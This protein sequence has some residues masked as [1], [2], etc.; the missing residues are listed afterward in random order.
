[1]VFS[2]YKFLVKQLILKLIEAVQRGYHGKEFS[3]EQ[4]ANCKNGFISK[5]H[6]IKAYRQL[7]DVSEKGKT[8]GRMTI[9]QRVGMFAVS[10]WRTG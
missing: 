8:F 4:E 3:E 10:M 7:T 9:Y 1:M 2:S 6:Q 5:A